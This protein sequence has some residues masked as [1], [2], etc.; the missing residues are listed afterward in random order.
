MNSV[1]IP[2]ASA[3]SGL[4]VFEGLVLPFSQLTIVSGCLPIRS[5]SSTCVNP[6][7]FLSWMSL[8]SYVTGKTYAETPLMIS[9]FQ[10][11]CYQPFGQVKRL[12]KT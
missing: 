12:T 1:V 3:S 7:S 11:V 9:D 6:R 10:I 2:S 5:A 4:T 8:S